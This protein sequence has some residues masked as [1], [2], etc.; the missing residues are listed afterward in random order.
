MTGAVLS[1]V[2]TLICAAGLDGEA[3]VMIQ[4]WFMT[5]SKPSR[6]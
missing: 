4:P 3:S 1:L 6:P 5:S 2:M